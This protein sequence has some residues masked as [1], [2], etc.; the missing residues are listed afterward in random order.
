MGR[1]TN[2]A[3]WL[4]KYSRWQLKVQKDGERRTFTS[5]TPG[6]VGQ[7]ECN[8]KADAWLDDGIIS[9]E[10]RVSVLFDA[11]IVELKANTGTSH[12]MKYQ[13]FWRAWI[14]PQIGQLKIGAVTEQK[15]Q[16]I[17][18]KAHKKGLAK[19]SLQNLRACMVAFVKYARMGKAT[20]LLPENVYIPK[21]APVGERV[22]LQPTDLQT[23]FNVDTTVI[24]GKRVHEP[25]VYAFRLEVVTGLR[26]GELLGLQWSDIKGSVITI[27][28]SYNSHKEYTKGKNEN[29]LRSFT[30]PTAA[31]ESIAAYR[32]NLGDSITFSP[33][34]FPSDHQTPLSP[35]TYRDRWTK[36]KAHNG[37]DAATHLYDLRHTF[38]SINKVMPLGLLQPLVGHSVNMDT[39]KTYGHEVVGDSE[40]VADMIQENFTQALEKKAKK[41][42]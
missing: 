34:V 37:L 3:K 11:W 33:F 30:L 38:V 15:L 25:L 42:E 35:K 7:R 21:G 39:F 24:R 18:N 2:T 16:D 9:S 22:I 20:T 5:S 28:R 41:A 13:S 27:R 8:A 4:E 29:A 1:R 23:L 10:T 40:I 26:P 14:S 31:L 12:W 6:R 32:A 36:Y 19:K 17:V